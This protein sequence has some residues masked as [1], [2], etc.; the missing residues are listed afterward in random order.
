MGCGRLRGGLQTY[1]TVF[2][3]TE[4]LTIL[5]SFRH[6]S[7]KM[8]YEFGALMLEPHCPRALLRRV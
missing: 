3:T 1:A 8:I 6:G 7:A 5:T 2:W 4:D